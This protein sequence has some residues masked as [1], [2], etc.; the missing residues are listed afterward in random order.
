[1]RP[2][3]ATGDKL[4]ECAS[5]AVYPRDCHCERSE[6]IQGDWAEAF[7][8]VPLD[9]FVAT[10]LAMTARSSRER[11]PKRRGRNPAC[12]QLISE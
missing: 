6:A 1:M 11:Q 9:C 12:N 2:V 3:R 4:L 8:P 5:G 7:H 10:L